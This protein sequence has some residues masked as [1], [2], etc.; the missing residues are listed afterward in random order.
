MGLEILHM[1][2]TCKRL[3]QVWEQLR[4]AIYWTRFRWLFRQNQS[5]SSRNCCNGIASCFYQ[6]VPWE[7][8]RMLSIVPQ[9]HVTTWFFWGFM[10][11]WMELWTPEVNHLVW[12]SVWSL[13]QQTL[14]A[15]DWCSAPV[16][17]ALWDSTTLLDDLYPVARQTHSEQWSDG[18]LGGPS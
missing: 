12:L 2:T 5:H 1:A 15:V 3:L 10:E 13:Y 6:S 18:A 14:V 4:A 17:D 7:Q 8:L 9:T 16:V 11:S